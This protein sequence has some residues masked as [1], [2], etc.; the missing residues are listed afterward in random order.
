MPD[1]HFENEPGADIM[2]G[3]HQASMPI[4]RV[5][6]LFADKALSFSL[7][8]GA[9]FADLADRLDPMGEWH[10]GLPTAVYL[11]F[12]TARQPISEVPTEL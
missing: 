6:A 9:T 5:V 2:Q 4:H 8:A 1:C 7:S 3:T 12:G 10:T 11:K